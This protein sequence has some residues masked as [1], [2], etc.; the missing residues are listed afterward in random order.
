MNDQNVQEFINVRKEAARQIDPE[1]AEV[2]WSYGQIMDPYG[3][4]PDLPD[5]LQCVGRIYFA[6]A[7]GSD[8][9]V[10]FYDLPKAI[11]DALWEKHKRKL[12][13]PAGLPQVPKKVSTGQSKSS[14]LRT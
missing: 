6:R 1:N 5:E 4:D 11:R 10:S 7:S 12:G 2:D 14:R 8:I 13:F 9:W 3:I